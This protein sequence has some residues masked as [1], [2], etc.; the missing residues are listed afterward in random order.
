MA[1]SDLPVSN[2]FLAA[3]PREDL[4]HLRPHLEPVD[5]PLRQVLHEV[6]EP[7]EHIYFHDGGMTSLLIPLEDGAILE[8]GVVGKE[9]LVGLPA[10][11]GAVTAP[12]ESMVQMPGAASRIRTDALRAAMP[13]SL[14]LLDR[15]LRYSQ[16]LH[17]QVSRTAVCNVHHNLQERLARWL[18]MAHD[19]AE[20]DML[21]LTQE[22]LSMMLGVR[23]AGV[24]VAAHILQEAG[25]IRYCRGRITVADRK[26]LEASSCECYGAV[27]AEVEQLFG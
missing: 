16:A 15:V 21:P 22:F 25:A 11:L 19:R 13:R 4:D 12:H 18:L 1:A 9:G 27:T 24:T 2:L 7:I 8:V 5:L 17:A 20:A 3:L 6:G 14:A 10:L 26:R 23:R